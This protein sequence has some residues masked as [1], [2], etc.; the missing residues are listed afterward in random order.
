VCYNVTGPGEVPLRTAIRETGGRPAAAAEP[1][2]RPLLA[3]LFRAGLVRIPPGSIDYIKYPCTIAG[4]RFAEATGFRP[5][6]GLK[7]SFRSLR[8]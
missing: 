7:E 8:R 5:L 4:E 2:A 6:F 3:R 1:V